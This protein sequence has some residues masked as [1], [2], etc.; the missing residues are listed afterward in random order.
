[1]AKPYHGHRRK[2]QFIKRDDFPKYCAQKCID[3]HLPCKRQFKQ[4]KRTSSAVARA[5]SLLFATVLTMSRIN[6]HS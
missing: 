3:A 5:L 1:L 2:T 4:K 6:A